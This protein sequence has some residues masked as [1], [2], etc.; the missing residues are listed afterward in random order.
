MER[1]LLPLQYNHKVA[2]LPGLMVKSSH[3]EARLAH[4][5]TMKMYPCLTFDR[6]QRRLCRLSFSVVGF[7]G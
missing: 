4:F 5:L 7:A 6:V 3:F 2:V 1:P